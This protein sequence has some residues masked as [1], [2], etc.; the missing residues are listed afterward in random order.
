MI[1]ISSLSKS[2]LGK[3]VLNNVSLVLPDTGL[4]GVVGPSGCGKTTFLSCLSG[5]LPFNGHIQFNNK[6]L[7]TLSEKELDDFRLHKCG[8]VF[9]DFKLFINET[10]YRNVYFPL[11]I[12]SSESKQLKNRRVLD[13]LS[14]VGLKKYKDKLIS[15]MSGGEKQRIAIARALANSPKLLLCDE[16]TGSL[17]SKN[18]YE[19]MK[20]LKRISLS[21]LVVVVTHDESLIE[22]FADR[23]IS[24][25]DGTV[26]SDRYPNKK[27]DIKFEHLPL[28]KINY[29]YKKPTISQ[30]F[31]VKHTLFSLKEKKF[32]TIFSTLMTSLGLLGVGL[33]LS[34]SSL[35]SE[36]IKSS[37]SAIIDEDQLIVEKKEKTKEDY[38]TTVS[39]YDALD[40][41][42]N[43]PQYINDVGVHYYTNYETFF[44]TRNQFYIQAEGSKNILDGLSSRCINEFR[45]LDDSNDTFYPMKPSSLKD[46]EIAVSFTMDMIEDVCFALKIKRSVNSL[47]EY[48]LLH[49]LFI[50]LDVA[51]DNWEYEDEQV[52]NVKAFS[53]SFNNAIYHYNHLW[54]EYMFEEQMRFPTTDYLNKELEKPYQ[55]RKIYYLDLKPDFIEDFF[56]TMIKNQEYE[57]YRFELAYKYY[58][59]LYNEVDVKDVSRVLMFYN[60]YIDGLTF[61]TSGYL[62]D[63]SNSLSKETF[64]TNKGIAIYPSSL[65][66]GFANSM[67]A[68]CC[69]DKIDEVNDVNSYLSPEEARKLIIPEGV[70]GGCYYKVKSE[71][72]TFSP[73]AKDN[74]LSLNEIY[75]SS[76]L[77][78]TLFGNENSLGKK[79]Y[80]SYVVDEIYFG[81]KKVYK[82]FV[83][84]ELVIR[85]IYE[86]EDKVI[87]HNSY[88]SI[89]YFQLHLGI[90]IFD[91]E[92][93]N[94][95]FSVDKDYQNIDDEF[96]Q[97]SFVRPLSE[98]NKSIEEV[99]NYLTTALII[100]SSICILISILMLLLINNLNILDC[101]KDMYLA[102]VIGVSKKES[103]KFVSMHTIL[104][105]FLSL[106]FAIV[107]LV[108]MTFFISKFI[109][110]GE[111]NLNP[112][113]FLAMFGVPLLICLLT[114]FCLKLN[115]LK[116]L[117]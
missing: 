90:S 67:F 35:V 107:E 114:M 5:L 64:G 89:L 75:I 8:F 31:L 52:L 3:E 85:G 61:C 88:W 56:I 76:S 18:S 84:D 46:D 96:P 106:F 108:I 47:S 73:F 93:N 1:E 9:Q 23:V 92:I 71:G 44:S 87:Y 77:S 41:K 117:K 100:F 63:A 14:L 40:L 112:F 99:V 27:S 38:V 2:F 97:Y 54:N 59:Y 102:R 80:I 51:N 22:M 105:C 34:I 57:V 66:M 30:G 65:L 13:L 50:V 115:V 111:F 49:D 6:S 39:Y 48:L 104:T 53:L 103:A 98:V 78:K 116:T 58:L 91:L 26:I 16:P 60:P 10:A 42:N 82:E 20:I 72:L 28:L 109:I 69:Q 83:N 7:E 17:D 29:S 24:L 15:K 43:F 55:L 12:L 62:K 101:K 25:K 95:A 21:S 33:C 110:N 4:I 37:Y 19:I 94:I 11:D 113:S 70:V 45:Y 74:N 68:S 36:S 81:D 86:S 32:R 79:L